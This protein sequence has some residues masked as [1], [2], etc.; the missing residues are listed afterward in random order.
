MSNNQA[1]LAKL[2]TRR[3][4]AALP[5]NWLYKKANEQPHV[6]AQFRWDKQSDKRAE[7]KFDSAI[8]VL[9]QFESSI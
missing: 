7:L 5:I 4:L 2:T 8:F 6:C 1:R 3:A 9:E